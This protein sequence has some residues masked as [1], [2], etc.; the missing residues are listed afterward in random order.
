MAT[1]Q[2]AIPEPNSEGAPVAR[3][4]IVCTADEKKVY[5]GRT[6]GRIRKPRLFLDAGASG[7]VSKER[8]LTEIERDIAKAPRALKRTTI[9][10]EKLLAEQL[11]EHKESLKKLNKRPLV[12]HPPNA[13][14]PEQANELEGGEKSDDGIPGIQEI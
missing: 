13:N 14:E 5:V 12:W 1:V 11:A 9:F 2:M 3:V 8:T 4:A 7:K 10:W 6:T